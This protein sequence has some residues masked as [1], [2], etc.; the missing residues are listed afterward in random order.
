MSA[1]RSK[2]TIRAL[3]SI[4]ALCQLQTFTNIHLN[5][6]F[7]PLSDGRFLGDSNQILL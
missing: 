6:C 2:P 3:Q 4:G 1:P 7:G 5:W